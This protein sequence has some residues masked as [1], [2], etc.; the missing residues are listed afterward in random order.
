MTNAKIKGKITQEG[1]SL[2]RLCLWSDMIVIKMHKD[3]RMEL[4]GVEPHK[5]T[6]T[7]ACASNARG[8]MHVI[9]KITP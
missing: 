6:C 7:S 8:N 5:H 9:N 4:I 3:T 2:K 1:K